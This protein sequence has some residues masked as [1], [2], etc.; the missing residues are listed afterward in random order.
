MECAQ[1]YAHLFSFENRNWGILLGRM[2]ASG[3]QTG[4]T[5]PQSPAIEDTE[6]RTP[7]WLPCRT[8]KARS[9]QKSN[10]YR[11]IKCRTG[12][13]QERGICQCLN[14]AMKENQA[15]EFRRQIW[16]GPALYFKEGFVHEYYTIPIQWPGLRHKSKQALPFT[17]IRDAVLKPLHS[18]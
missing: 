14:V 1:S 10:S 9:Y 18:P 5:L 17:F 16:I 7:P 12:L 11:H 4:W 6:Q 2:V 15:R 3:I 13:R 8:C